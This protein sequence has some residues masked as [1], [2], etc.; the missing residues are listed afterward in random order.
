MVCTGTEQFSWD[1]GLKQGLGEV[2]LEGLAEADKG[3][4]GL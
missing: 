3:G 1:T 4:L 2:G